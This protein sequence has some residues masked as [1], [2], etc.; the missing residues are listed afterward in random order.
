MPRV[1]VHITA[2]FA[3]RRLVPTHGRD[4]E[5]SA[6]GTREVQCKRKSRAQMGQVNGFQTFNGLARQGDRLHVGKK[7]PFTWIGEFGSSES[8]DDRSFYAFS[9]QMTALLPSC[10]K[11]RRLCWSVGEQC[12]LATTC[13]EP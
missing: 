12:L 8:L 6:P 10:K 7:P 3:G 9:L 1:E 11:P 5:T 13:P 4:S 2:T